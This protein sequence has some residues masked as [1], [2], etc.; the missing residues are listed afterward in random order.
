M[1]E[2]LLSAGDFACKK[3]E[4]FEEG[5]AA[6]RQVSQSINQLCESADG[7]AAIWMEGMTCG[8]PFGCS[9]VIAF[10]GGN[11]KEP[12]A[13]HFEKEDREGKRFLYATA[14]DKNIFGWEQL[15]SGEW[16]FFLAPGSALVRRFRPGSSLA[17][18]LRKAEWEIHI[19]SKKVADVKFLDGEM[20]VSFANGDIVGRECKEGDGYHF[21]LFDKD[22]AEVAIQVVA[23]LSAMDVPRK[24]SAAVEE[25]FI[26]VQIGEV[27][28]PM[29]FEE[30]SRDIRFGVLHPSERFLRS[31]FGP[32]YKDIAWMDPEVP[33]AQLLRQREEVLKEWHD[34]LYPAASV[35]R[36]P[37]YTLW[38]SGSGGS[39]LLFVPRGGKE[40]VYG[41][42]IEGTEDL[43]AWSNQVVTIL[44]SSEVRWRWGFD[45]QHLAKTILAGLTQIKLE[46]E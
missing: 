17:E 14:S 20:V 28:S 6:T 44:T 12:Q 31:H 2:Q 4:S 35:T 15:P 46:K 27:P 30:I 1:I 25:D 23:L 24:F 18:A 10:G 7:Q 8:S 32:R 19:A 45:R 37:E 34:G 33:L 38:V 21:V 13:I 22:E 41:V 26:R 29:T 39:S 40:E 9:R 36:T 5:L 3:F 43:T 11:F 42:S 16:M